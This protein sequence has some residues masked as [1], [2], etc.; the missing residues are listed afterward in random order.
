GWLL[1][2][3]PPPAAESLLPPAATGSTVPAAAP[4]VVVQAAGAVQRPGL[5]RLPQGA[6]GADLV[7]AAGGPAGDADPD[8]VHLAARGLHGSQVR[9]P[10]VGEPAAPVD[11]GPAPGQPLDLNA[12]TVDQLEELPGV[13]PATAAAIVAERTRRGGFRSVDELVEVRGIGP[14]KL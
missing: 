1:L 9:V 10:R 7:E 3:D 14:A 12:A 6:R 4:E 5:Y 11:A 13:G 8:P 2:R